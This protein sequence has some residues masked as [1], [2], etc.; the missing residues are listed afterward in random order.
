MLYPYHVPDPLEVHIVGTFFFHVGFN[1]GAKGTCEAG[2]ETMEEGGY[3]VLKVRRV[4]S[5]SQGKRG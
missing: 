4:F 1:G 2:T 3:P 5:Q